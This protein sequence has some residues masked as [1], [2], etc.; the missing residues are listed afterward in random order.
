MEATPFACAL[1]SRF[2]TQ[3]ILEIRRL[4]NNSH[5][6]HAPF[7]INGMKKLRKSWKKKFQ[8][9]SEQK[10]PRKKQNGL[11]YSEKPPKH[12]H[13]KTHQHFQTFPFVPSARLDHCGLPLGL[14]CREALL[15]ILSAERRRLVL[16]LLVSSSLPR[17]FAHPSAQPTIAAKTRRHEKKV[18]TPNLSLVLCDRDCRR[19]EEKPGATRAR[20][21]LELWGGV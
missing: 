19:I 14:A 21:Y 3:F 13:S 20:E 11:Q 8:K 15:P 7:V 18:P 10:I 17:K 6:L 16:M 5:Q 12:I 4:R 2:S 9:K 1:I